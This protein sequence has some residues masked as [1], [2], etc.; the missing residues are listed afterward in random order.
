MR[1]AAM[2]TIITRC[3]D[4]HIFQPTYILGEDEDKDDGIRPLLFDLAT[5]DSKK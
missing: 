2:L 5:A 4:Q 1:I 3:I